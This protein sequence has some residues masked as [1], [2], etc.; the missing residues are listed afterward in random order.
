MPEPFSLAGRAWVPVASAKGQRAFVRLRDLTSPHPVDGETIVRLATGRADC[1]TALAEFLIGLLAVTFGPEDTIAWKRL[2]VSPPTADEIEA[3]LAPFAAALVFDGKGP[4]FFQDRAELEAGPTPVEALFIDAPADHFLVDLRYETLSRTGA[5]IALLTLQ[6]MAPSGGAGHRTSARGGGPLTTFVM[7]C[8]QPTLWQWLW[9][10][11]PLGLKPAPDEL[12]LVMPWLAATRT[13]NPNDGGVITTPDDGALAAQAFFGMPRRI[14]LNFETNTE[15]RACDLTGEIDDVI[16]RNYVTRP[17]GVNYP[18]SAWRHPLS[19]YYKQKK[20]SPESLPVHLKSSRI[21]YRDWLGLVNATPD[22]LKRP[23]DIV[24]E[25][26]TRRA[27][28]IRGDGERINLFACG[29]A[30]DNMKPLDFGEALL[31]LFATGSEDTDKALYD[32]ARG[33]IAAA[34]EAAGQLTRA[35]RQALFGEKA[36]VDAGSTVLSAVATRFWSE[37]EAPFYGSLQSLNDRLVVDAADELASIRAVGK[38]W[39]EAVRRSALAIFDDTAPIEDSDPE[40]LADVITARKFLSLTFAGLT[41]TGG[42]I[43]TALDLPT[44][45]K[46]AA[47]KKARKAKS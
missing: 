9:A 12:A 33:M 7:P 27:N 37:T 19:P 40:R 47:G 21:G 39:L 22:T 2:Y 32:T 29:Y 36:K 26:R 45:D 35:I 6:T 10:N 18:S 23:A 43:Y 16:V 46:P 5:A 4:R 20:D 41:P 1:D 15:Q 17:W 31:P 8:A 24:H 30:L 25:F 42:K 11:V 14:R 13:S 3:A 44:P 34:E 38:D 28:L